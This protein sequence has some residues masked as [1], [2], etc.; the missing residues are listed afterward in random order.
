MTLPELLKNFRHPVLPGDDRVGGLHCCGLLFAGR[1]IKKPGA[2]FKGI[3]ALQRCAEF[4]CQL[5]P[6][7]RVAPR[8]LVCEI[9]SL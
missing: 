9:P 2:L 4:A 7:V 3:R 8:M 5:T 6:A 1:K